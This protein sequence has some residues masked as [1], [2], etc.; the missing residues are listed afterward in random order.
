MIPEM[1]STFVVRQSLCLPQTMNTFMN[2]I[3]T[4]NKANL[5]TRELKVFLWILLFS[6]S[7][8]QQKPH[9]EVGFEKP[10]L[11]SDQGFAQTK[12]NAFVPATNPKG[13][14]WIPGGTFSMGTNERNE[15]LCSV[16]GI[17]RDATPVHPVY[18]DGFWMD[19]HEVTND[20]FAAFVK[21]TGYITVAEQTPTKE[22]FPDT[23]PEMLKAGSVVFS[24]PAETVSLE[25]HLQWWEFVFG[26]N[27]KHP[28]GPESTIQGKGNFPVVHVA[29]EDAFAYAKWAGK[30]LPTEAE[31]EFASRG[32]VSGEPFE[33]G[34]SFKSNNQ[35]MAN[36]FQGSFP[37]RDDGKDG[38]K[39]MAPVKQYSQ[40][41]YGLYDM[42]GNVWEWC[43]DWYDANYFK[44]LSKNDVTKNP[45]GPGKSYDPDEPMVAKKVHRGGSYL[46]TDQYCSRYVV[47]TRGKGDWRTG[48][49]HV[50]FRTVKD[51]NKN[52][53]SC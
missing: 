3:C 37:N 15:S 33:W 49:N 11:E 27:W 45:K 5:M 23:L 1:K 38:F 14:V 20:E 50:G 10:I 21:A 9:K 16:K 43:S 13:M 8:C 46:C 36:T 39:G 7:A 48:T 12:E 6:I 44:T 18:V 52:Q 42:S 31:W 2:L 26:A 40:N 30:R 25:N 4:N 35:Y 53:R 32:G 51:Y 29:W 41:A 28:E 19:D 24:P 17:T 47:G 34:E 22:E